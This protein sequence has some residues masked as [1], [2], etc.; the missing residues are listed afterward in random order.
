MEHLAAFAFAVPLVVAGLL[1]AGSSRIPRVVVD[2]ATLGTAIFSTTC[3]IILFV[4][5]RGAPLVYWFGEWTPRGRAAIGIDFVVDSLGAGVASVAGLLVVF[6]LI[7]S[8]RYFDEVKALFHALMLIFLASMTAFSFAG[9]LFNIF[10]FFE[11]MSISAFALTGYKIEEDSLEGAFNFGITNSIAGF[12]LLTSIGYL[13]ARTGSL[14]LAGM[15]DRLSLSPHDPLVAMAFVF[16]ITALFIKGGI[17]PFHFWVA[18]A[19]AVAPIPVCVVLSGILDPLWIYGATQFYWTLFSGPLE[20][21]QHR[22]RILFLI[23][24]LLTA[25]V[26]AL[27]CSTQRHLKR[28]LAFSS[29]SHMGTVLAGFAFFGPAALAGALLYLAGHAFIKGSLFFGTGNLMNRFGSVDEIDLYGRGKEMR[30]TGLLFA[31][32][33]LA[34]G[35]LPPFGIW[36]ADTIVDHEMTLHGFWW[37]GV[38]LVAATA[39]TGA[40]VLRAGGHVF[41]GAGTIED[42]QKKAPTADERKETSGSSGRTPLVMILPVLLTLLAAL[43]PATIRPVPAA[44]REAAEHFVDRSEYAALVLDGRVPPPAV[45][46]QPRGATQIGD[47]ALRGLLATGLMLVMA[48]WMLLRA[49]AVR[50]PRSRNT[51]GIIVRPLRKSLELLGR[52]HSGKVADYVAWIV[53]G[54]AVLGLVLIFPPCAASSPRGPRGSDLEG[55]SVSCVAPVSRPGL[56]IRA[57]EILITRST[58]VHPISSRRR[59]P[60]VHSKSRK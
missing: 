47:A 20:P 16:G 23:L 56:S 3:C 14:N 24:G 8:I 59:H 43:L 30:G 29:V 53:V 58:S 17:V 37:S 60:P 12:L 33:G 57:N 44:F 31:I 10:V 42:L 52:L 21:L 4:A 54:V 40:T 19:H 39:L 26:G 27:M 51:A 45:E 22:L 55:P 25:V 18:D 1:V 7:Y 34:L 15:G 2:L 11:L 38:V 36:F 28:M 9:D 46:A 32:G 5:S 48:T 13:Y 6:A 41:L 50:R 35:G 49:P